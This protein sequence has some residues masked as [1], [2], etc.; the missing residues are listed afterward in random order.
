MTVEYIIMKEYKVPLA[1][2]NNALVIAIDNLYDGKKKN[3]VSG[4]SL[5]KIDVKTIIFIFISK[6]STIINISLN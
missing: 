4:S 5:A 1:P 3:V 6:R 2:I